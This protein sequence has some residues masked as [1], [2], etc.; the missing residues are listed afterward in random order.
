[1]SHGSI[2]PVQD[3]NRKG[4]PSTANTN[5]AM[6]G[7]RAPRRTVAIA[8]VLAAMVLVVLDAAIANV[9]L[10]TITRSL[11][12]TP[13]KSIWVI[14]AYQTA[15]LMALLPCAALGESLGYRRIFT[16]GVALFTVASVLCAL[17]PSLSWLVAARFLQGI[18][19]AA[20]LALG[21]ALL[22]DVVSRQ[23]LGAAIGW[24]AIAVSLASAAGPAF[25]ATVLS[26]TS[27]PLLFAVNLPLGVL[28]LLGTRALPDS[29]GTARRMDL[30][31]V[32]LNGGVFASLVSG[33]ELLPERPAPGRRHTRRSCHS[34][35]NASSARNTERGATD[36]VRLAPH[37]FI[38]LFC[39]RLGL[40]FWR[41][42]REHDCATFLPAARARAGYV[43]GRALYDCLAVDRGYRRPLRRQ[44]R[45]PHIDG[46]A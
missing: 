22:R 46:L 11:H 21:V 44:S 7:I 12:V 25:G 27:W 39:D 40:L 14:T 30:F 23:R 33:A 2:S 4:M 37:R 18:G 17:S 13:A 43:D 45:G 16:G 42:D 9:A 15:L 20:V 34:T 29:V 3:G 36:S 19:G 1:M 10:P 32:A 26:A 41:A 24:N 35:G 6:S 31:S 5:D 28:V 8:S 38:P